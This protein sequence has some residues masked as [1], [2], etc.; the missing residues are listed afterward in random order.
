MFWRWIAAFDADTARISAALRIIPTQVLQLS[1]SSVVQGS[2]GKQVADVSEGRT[3]RKLTLTA[4][5]VASVGW[6]GAIVAFLV[7]ALNASWRTDDARVRSAA[8][9][10]QLVGWSAIVPFSIA[11]LLT[12]LVQSWTTQ[13]GF[14]R[15]YWVI[16]KLLITVV[17]SGLLLQGMPRAAVCNHIFNTEPKDERFSAGAHSQ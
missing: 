1:R 11:A 5:I 3:F 17:S 15:H 12:G 7:V 9:A 14:F 10:M 13:W 16:A 6:L 8:E 2:G 4:H